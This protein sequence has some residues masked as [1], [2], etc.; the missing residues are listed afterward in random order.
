MGKTTLLFWRRSK[1]PVVRILQITLFTLFSALWALACNP[2]DSAGPQKDSFAELWTFPDVSDNR[3]DVP[4]D[5]S[6]RTDIQGDADSS[7]QPDS[8]SDLRSDTFADMLL[9]THLDAHPDS[10]PDIQLDT[11]LEPDA[12]SDIFADAE[13]VGPAG[14][15]AGTFLADFSVDLY[16]SGTGQIGA[17]AMTQNSGTVVVNGQTLR[18]VVSDRIEWDTPQ[19]HYTLYQLLGPVAQGLFV[20]YVYCLGT[21]LDYVYAEGF[22]LPMTGF[23]ASGTCS[24]AVEST[25]VQ[26]ELTAIQTVPS[27]PFE[28]GMVDLQ[29]DSIDIVDGKG[30]AEVDGGMEAT[31][32]GFVDCMECPSTDGQGWYE[33][34]AVLHKNFPERVCFGIFYVYPTTFQIQFGWGFCMT[35]FTPLPGQM[36]GTATY[37]LGT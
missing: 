35:D 22:T 9:D 20:T 10:L 1:G 37:D 15:W 27:P 18:M 3:S 13:V 11:P 17:I 32:F 28:L 30:N 6:P 24:L 29:G 8:E 14:D 19:G 21:K 23:P 2:Q 4:D 16:G 25:Q 34:H 7:A 36:L 33:F 12:P 31:L 26:A 5:L